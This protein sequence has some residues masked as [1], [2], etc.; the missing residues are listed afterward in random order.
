M[1]KY[2]G[3]DGRPPAC[4]CLLF[5]MLLSFTARKHLYIR[6]VMKQ[7]SI[8]YKNHMSHCFNEASVD[9]EDENNHNT[10]GLIFDAIQKQ[11]ARQ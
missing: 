6:H 10:F 11:K 2:S 3:F 5:Y 9:Y 7:L 8:F 1:L 4:V